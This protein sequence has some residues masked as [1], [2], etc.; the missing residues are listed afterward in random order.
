MESFSFYLNAFKRFKDYHTPSPRKEFNFFIL[1]YFVFWLVI[2]IPMMMVV[3]YQAMS[4]M[5][6]ENFNYLKLI[7]PFGLVG[8]IFYLVHIVPLLALIKRRLIDI[9][10]QKASLIFRIYVA[11][12]I[13][14]LLITL[15][16]PIGVYFLQNVITTSENLPVASLV[17]IWIIG[18]IN[19]ALSFLVLA[20]YIFLMVKQGNIGKEE[21]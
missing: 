5:T 3:F 9:F 6:E 2:F 10:S 16:Y 19:N 14:R 1:F 21:K 20:F 7:I 12:E 4:S 8:W 11:I 18:L 15:G 13:I 17:V